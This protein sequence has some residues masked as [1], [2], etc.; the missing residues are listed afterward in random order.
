MIGLWWLIDQEWFY[1]ATILED[2]REIW[3]RNRLN[4]RGNDVGAG[5]IIHQNAILKSA[6]NDPSILSMLS[7]YCQAKV[8]TIN[9]KGLA[10]WTEA[11]RC[12]MAS[13]IVVAVHA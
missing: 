6:V 5:G 3:I 4:K 1:Q 2:L 13:M 12:Y 11:D 7:Q 9:T 10:D 8:V